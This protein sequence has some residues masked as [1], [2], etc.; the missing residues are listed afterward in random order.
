MSHGGGGGEGIFVGKHE[1]KR[2]VERRGRRSDLKEIGCRVGGGGAGTGFFWLKG[3]KRNGLDV[4]GSVHH[5]INR[6]EITNK[7]RPCSRIY[8]SKVS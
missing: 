6:I 5:N 8:Y 4:H 3:G 7:M 1:G 2:R